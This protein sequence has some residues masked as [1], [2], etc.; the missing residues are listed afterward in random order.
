[1]TI[2]DVDY[3]KA[4]DRA[5]RHRAEIELMLERTRRK[6]QREQL[7]PLVDDITRW[8]TRIVRLAQHLDDHL[9]P[10]HLPA[11]AESTLQESLRALETTSARLQLLVAEGLDERRAAQPRIARLRAEI[12]DQVRVLQETMESLS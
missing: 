4:A 3:R 2:A 8:A 1:M 6:A 9:D 11:Q 7:R 5:L 10:D 12:A